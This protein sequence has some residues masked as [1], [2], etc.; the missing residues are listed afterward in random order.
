MGLNC[1]LAYKLARPGIALPLTM[2]S[3]AA[4]AF[5]GNLPDLDIVVSALL[6]DNHLKYHGRYSHAPVL[7]IVLTLLITFVVNK[8]WAPTLSFSRKALLIGAPLLSHPLID[9]LTGP[10][11]GPH[12]SY[13]SPL[14]WP[15]VDERIKAPVTLF[16]GPRH[17]TLVRFLGWHNVQV[18]VSE[19]VIFGS[20]TLYFLFLHRQKTVAP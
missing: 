9:S 17:D 18:V 15:W 7:L 2:T 16:L 5:L 10:N 8:R 13:G 20:F 12:T 3:A 11:W 6:S 1:L 4:F 14:L 19:L